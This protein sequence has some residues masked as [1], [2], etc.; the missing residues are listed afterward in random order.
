MA[1]EE[2]R[3][4]ERPA[5]TPPRS[6]VISGERARQGRIVLNTPARRWIFVTGLVLLVIVAILF[7]R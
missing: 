7:G 5:G 2:P 4:G 1:E 6:P 3:A